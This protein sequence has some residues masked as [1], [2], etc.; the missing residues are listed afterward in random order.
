MRARACYGP[1][2]PPMSFDPF[3][4]DRWTTTGDRRPHVDEAINPRIARKSAMFPGPCVSSIERGV[5]GTT[6]T[7]VSL[8]NR[9]GQARLDRRAR[10]AT[11][12]IP[13]SSAIDR[14]HGK[15]AI[16]FEPL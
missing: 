6:D 12:I 10:K 11:R 9:L 5:Q 16:T 13:T 7:T 3:S 8:L 4:R 14:T 2:I 1:Y 15:R